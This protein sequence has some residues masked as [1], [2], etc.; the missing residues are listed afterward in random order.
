MIDDDLK[1]L[2]NL[3]AP[4]VSESAKERAVNAAMDAF[5][6]MHLE[7]K[8]TA[9][10]GIESET[11]PT[12]ILNTIWSGLMNSILK[13][14]W[15]MKP[16]AMAAVAG[17]ML[18]PVVGVIA[19]DSYEVDNLYPVGS[20]QGSNSA[21]E[22]VVVASEGTV[23]L[24]KTAQKPLAENFTASGQNQLADSAAEVSVAQP[25][26]QALRKRSIGQ[27]APTS[28]PMV[29]DGVVLSRPIPI[30]PTIDNERFPEFKNN[31]VKAVVNEPVSTFSIDVD[32][33]S[34]SRVRRSIMDG[35]L[36]STDMV[37]VE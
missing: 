31:G 19:L 28:A 30:A 14:V 27:V 29:Q 5:D 24:K 20:E 21:V 3:K 18:V 15:E 1:K 32:T 26:V 10:Q 37:R 7:N 2:G 9:T 23:K 33:A 11:R 13:P 12:S 36:P 22:P 16:A 34:Y 6:A 35:I 4:A 8:S 25:R 17:V